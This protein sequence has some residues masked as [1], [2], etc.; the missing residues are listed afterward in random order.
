[1]N[2]AIF[3]SCVVR[4]AVWF[5]LKRLL[6][7]V[8]PDTDFVSGQLLAV[9]SSDV[10]TQAQYLL[11]CPALTDCERKNLIIIVKTELENDKSLFGIF[12]AIAEGFNVEVNKQT[13]VFLF[14]YV[15]ASCIT[16]TNE[17]LLNVIAMYTHFFYRIARYEY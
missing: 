8:V 3:R 12:P 1:M 6:N 2:L 4:F 17:L 14:W 5:Q 11:Q 13:G 16:Y 9:E 7:S 10:K 15:G